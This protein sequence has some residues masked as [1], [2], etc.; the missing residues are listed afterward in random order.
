MLAYVKNLARLSLSGLVCF[1]ENRVDG[2]VD[3]R[4]LTYVDASSGIC[5]ARLDALSFGNI[6]DSLGEMSSILGRI[7][8]DR[9]HRHTSR[10]L[11]NDE[12]RVQ[13]AKGFVKWGYD[14]S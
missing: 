2:F 13:A 11:F 10:H 5:E 8:S 9:S 7:N 1:R 12:K 3:L 14:Q 4:N 6:K